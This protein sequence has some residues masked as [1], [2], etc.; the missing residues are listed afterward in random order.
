MRIIQTIYRTSTK[1]R[2]C[3]FQ[4][5]KDTLHLLK[6]HVIPAPEDAVQLA[7][8][9]RAEGFAG[10]PL[11][12]GLARQNTTARFF[13]FPTQQA[14]EIDKMVRYEAQAM[15]PL[16]PE[17]IVV[18]YQLLRKR[19]DGYSEV[20]AVVAQR[21][22]VL[23]AVRVIEEAGARVDG[24]ALSTLALNAAVQEQLRPGKARPGWAAETFALAY[25]EDGGAEFCVYHQDALAFSRAT[26]LSGAAALCAE[27]RR[28]LELFAQ[29]HADKS[30]GCVVVAGAPEAADAVEALQRE[31]SLPVI[32]DP[33]LDIARGL[34]APIAESVDFLD[35]RRIA[36]RR[37]R[38]L[39]RLW[40]IAAALALVNAAL[41]V[42][43]FLLTENR[44]QQ[45]IAALERRVAAAKPQAQ[46]IQRK[47]QKIE[48]VAGQRRAQVLTL[49]ALT[50]I[51]RLS[52]AACTLNLLTLDESGVLVARGQAERLEDVFAFVDALDKSDFFRDSHLNFS[53]RRK[54][55]DRELL[56]FEI[57]ARLDE[58]GDAA[59]A[60]EIAAAASD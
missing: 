41:L 34:A 44:R 22:D 36:A 32:R 30:V 51:V 58:P 6:E 13:R 37:Q 49:E 57:Q 15:L 40:G 56:D 7:A 29:E 18:R 3:R 39:R 48:L 59:P 14:R 45:E 54:L 50:D 47:L 52:P 1:L 35:D 19:P 4:A 26:S 43:V 9:L 23:T 10:E 46:E 8:L 2:V 42:L 55:R 12:V 24:L 53:S 5:V 38:R 11:I 31:L 20:F 27:L 33:A 16:K 28:S 60:A 17:E 21:E 25:V